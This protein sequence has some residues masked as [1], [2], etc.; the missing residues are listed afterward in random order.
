MTPCKYLLVVE[1]VV[2]ALFALFAQLLILIAGT[3]VISRAFSL[4]VTRSRAHYPIWA[5]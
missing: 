5:R 4:L 3:I 1:L 2:V